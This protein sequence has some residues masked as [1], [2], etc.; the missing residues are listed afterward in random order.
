MIVNRNVLHKVDREIILELV[1][2]WVVL[3]LYFTG[4]VLNDKQIN[5]S[6]EVLKAKFEDAGIVGLQSTLTFNKQ[7][8]GFILPRSFHI[9]FIV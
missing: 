7:T 2:H 5:Y 9:C 3:Q 8:N 6:Q 1:N 4:L